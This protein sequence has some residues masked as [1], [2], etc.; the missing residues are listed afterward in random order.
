MRSDR[1]TKGKSTLE[2]IF[3]ACTRDSTLDFFSP[4]IQRRLSVTGIHVRILDGPAH[5]TV[6][7]VIYES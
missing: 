3:T 2:R 6:N 4:L 1:T 5:Y 7:F